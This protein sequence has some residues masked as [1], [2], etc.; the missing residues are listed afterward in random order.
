[1]PVRPINNDSHVCLVD[2]SAYIFRAFHALPP[3]TRKSDGTPIG[4]VSGFCNMLFKLLEDLKAADPPTH[5]ACIFDKSSKTF[6]NDLY[7]DYKANRSEP[8][9]DLVPQFSL[10]RRAAEAF[11][12]HAIEVEGYEADDIIATYSKQAEQEGAK[13]TIIGSDKDLMQLVSEKVRMLDTM[14][15]RE[16]GIEQVIEKFGVEP[17]K[18]IEIQALAGDSTDNIPGAPGIGIKTAAELIT[19]YGDVEQLL[20]RA[21]EIKQNKRRE[22]LLDEEVKEKVRVSKQLVTLRTDTPVDMP[23]EELAF[24]DPDPATLIAFLEEMEFKTITRRVREAISLEHPVEE[25][26]SIQEIDRSA[27][28]TVTKL[29]ELQQ[30]IDKARFLNVVAVDTETDSLNA[31]SAKLVG[32]SLCVG[33]NEACYVPLEHVSSNKDDVFGINKPEQVDKEQALKLLKTLMEDKNVLKVGHNIKYDSVVLAGENIF[34]SPMDDT[35]LLSFAL[36]AGKLKHGLDVLSEKFFEHKPIAYK[37]VCGTGKSEIGFDEVDLQ[38]ATE[39]AAEDADITFRLWKLLKPKL[40]EEQTA[41][42]YET[43]ERPLVA[44]IGAMECEGI[45]VSRETLRELSLDFHKRMEV[46]EQ[47][48]YEQAGTPFNLAS[49]QQ[50]GEILFENKGYP[51]GTKTK[52]GKWST[53]A[54]SLEELASQGH[55]LPKTILDWR[56]LAKLRSTYTEALLEAVNKKTGRVHTSFTMDGAQ[57]GRLASTA[58]NLQNIPIRTPDG[59]KIREAFIAEPGNVLIAADYSQIELRLLAHVAGIDS[60]RNAFKDGLDIHAMTASEMFGVPIDGMD[61]MIRRQAK[62]I[63]FGIIYGIS[64]FGLARQLGIARSQA[65]DYISAYFE[66]FPG[67][68][69]YMDDMKSFAQSNGFVRTIFGR[70]LHLQDINAK[71]HG[72]RSFAERQAINA[73]IQGTAADIIKRAMIR[74]PQAL[75]K[76]NLKTAMLLQVHDELVFEAPEQESE[77]AMGVIKSVMENAP[78]PSQRISVPLVVDIKAASTWGQAH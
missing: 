33:P 44:V 72:V 49:P 20:E 54:E 56:G 29:H 25:L 16:I 45:K 69:S 26:Q 28:K 4:A 76:E 66:K 15:D 22:T 38:K 37:E 11:A 58:P 10:V 17:N 6:R 9:E 2:A 14:K 32:F 43:I 31:T 47:K 53:N 74:L 68:K 30:W 55:D 77:T 59:R 36:N 40:A 73:P 35:M 71:N 46:L 52:S 24:T 7:P 5:F 78:L 70:K 41:T 23:L 8:P 13:V 63:N 61:P 3:L 21:N 67:I 42:L 18:V 39:Y 1:M 19:T 60:L 12:T 48:A 64:G 57:T 34:P 75:Q 50:V 51:G 27:Y 65:R 62:A